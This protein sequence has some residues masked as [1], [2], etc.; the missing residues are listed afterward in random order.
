LSAEHESVAQICLSHHNFE[1]NSVKEAKN[2]KFNLQ[3]VVPSTAN[4][5]LFR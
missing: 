3:D 1:K 4:F 2:D 5:F